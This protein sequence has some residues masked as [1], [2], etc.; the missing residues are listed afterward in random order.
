MSIFRNDSVVIPGTAR[1]M[2]NVQTLERWLEA[3]RK[4]GYDA[5]MPGTRNDKGRHRLPDEV[6]RQAVAL[7]Q[8][9]PERSV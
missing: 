2:L 3:Y 7:R 5:L 6:I 4:G 9:R 8:E 1:T